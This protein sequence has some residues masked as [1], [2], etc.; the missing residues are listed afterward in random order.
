M[1]AKLKSA[2]R[3]PQPALQQGKKKFNNK[4]IR[5]EKAFWF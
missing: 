4:K 5:N 2:T 3:N 1:G